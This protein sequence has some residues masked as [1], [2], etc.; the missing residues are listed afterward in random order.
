M[1]KNALTAVLILSTS[2]AAPA[3]S[4]PDSCRLQLFQQTDA[5]SD[6]MLSPTEAAAH[7]LGMDST[8]F[9]LADENHDGAL[10]LQEY[11]KLGV[12]VSCELCPAAPGC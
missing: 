2:S 6:G 7:P 11:E 4:A 12:F 10:D 3:Q 9:A 8:F 5:N 1:R